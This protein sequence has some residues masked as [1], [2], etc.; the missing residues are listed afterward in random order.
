MDTL[1][2][3]KDEEGWLTLNMGMKSFHQLRE[4]FDLYKHFKFKANANEPE[5]PLAQRAIVVYDDTYT[6]SKGMKKTVRIHA[7]F[8]PNTLRSVDN[9]NEFSRLLGKYIE[10]LEKQGKK[11]VDIHHKHSGDG[12]YDA[13]AGKAKA[14]Y[15]WKNAR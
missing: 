3:G 8:P 5:D 1:D 2:A 11:V 10:D 9:K 13:Y 15:A 4:V 12:K 7:M 14:G 6:D